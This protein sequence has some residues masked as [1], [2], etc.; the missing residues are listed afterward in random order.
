MTDF[1]FTALLDKQSDEF[2]LPPVL[3]AGI[4][5]ATVGDRHKEDATLKQGAYT[6]IT[7][8][9]KIISAYEVDEDQIAEFGDPKGS[10]LSLD[11]LFNNKPENDDQV[12][13]NERNMFRLRKFL[14]EH[15]GLGKGV[16]GEQLLAAQSAQFLVEVSHRAIREGSDEMIANITKTAPMDD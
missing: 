13:A 5:I 14:E 7:L 6:K 12:R 2:E 15:C 4:Y 1:N 8:P 11:F 9:I 16:L 3:P 10:R